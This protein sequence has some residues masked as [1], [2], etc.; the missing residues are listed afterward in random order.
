MYTTTFTIKIDEQ[1]LTPAV[2]EAL[3]RDMREDGVDDLSLPSIV[4][5]I[6]FE[7]MMGNRMELIQSMDVTTKRTND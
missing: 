2:I 5:Y 6:A 3:Q 7:S 1:L 4:E